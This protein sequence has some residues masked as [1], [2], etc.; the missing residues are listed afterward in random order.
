MTLALNLFQVSSKGKIDFL[1]VNIP[2]GVPI[3]FV[4]DPTSMTPIWI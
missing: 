1:F 2:K 3:P 4:F